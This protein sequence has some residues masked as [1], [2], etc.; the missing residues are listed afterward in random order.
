MKR[1][2]AMVFL[3]VFVASTTAAAGLEP[4]GK[5]KF[6]FEMQ[7]EFEGDR[8]I[9][10]KG[11]VPPELLSIKREIERERTTLLLM[12]YGLTEYLDLLAA[13]GGSQTKVLADGK[14]V[15]G[16]VVGLG[17]KAVYPLPENW[18][19]GASSQYLYHHDPV[20][21]EWEVAGYLGRKFRKLTPYLGLRYSDLRVRARGLRWK[22]KENWGA[23]VG[24]SYKLT[25]NTSLRLEV[26]AIGKQNDQICDGARVRLGVSYRF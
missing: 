12:G 17:F 3:T 2:M 14:F 4:L 8:D 15:W 22:A 7:Q 20:L 21:Q 19:V 13:I 25:S 23:F 10:T 5:G 24:G 11:E 1:W 9:K 26:E 6:S 18:L 16:G